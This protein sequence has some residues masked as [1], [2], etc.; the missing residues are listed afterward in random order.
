MRKKII[1]ALLILGGIAAAVPAAAPAVA[2]THYF[3]GQTA[4]VTATHYFG[5]LAAHYPG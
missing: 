3:G 5:K 1:P 4:H 2:A